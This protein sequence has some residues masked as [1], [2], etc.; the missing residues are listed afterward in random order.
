MPEDD[1][2]DRGMKG[3]YL[4]YAKTIRKSAEGITHTAHDSEM[5]LTSGKR[6]QM[7]MQGQQG[8][9]RFMNYV[10][11]PPQTH[12]DIIEVQF[13][14]KAGKVLVQQA[15]PGFG[16]LVASDHLYGE[17]VKIKFLTK[18]ATD[19]TKL[20]AGLKVTTKAKDI[21]KAEIEAL[22][23]QLE[24]KGN[25]AET[26]FFTLK[27]VWFNESAETYSTSTFETSVKPADLNE[28]Y[29]AGTLNAKPFALPEADK[30]LK[31]V[32]YLRNYEELIG[33]YSTVKPKK[34]AGRPTSA[35]TKSLTTNYEN[36]YITKVASIESLVRGLTTFLTD[37]PDLT[38]DK[39][40]A[41]AE[42]AATA[43]WNA[44]VALV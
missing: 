4:V 29:V 15:L 28:F 44:G 7:Q 41:K 20:Q 17:K 10:P 27:T 16:G 24:V 1:G 38:A 33:L 34:A 21:P 42:E 30:R 5:M 12:P 26:P 37:A 18:N 9:V 31:P 35:L 14:D 6:V 25:V 8:G 3:G 22:R 39:I 32:S 13:L 23:W 19:G 2:D 40:K 36:R 43:L 11:A